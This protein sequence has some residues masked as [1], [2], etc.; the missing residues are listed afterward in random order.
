[1]FGEFDTKLSDNSNWKT[2][3]VRVYN[4]LYAAKTENHYKRKNYD[5]V[6]KEKLQFEIEELT[7]NDKKDNISTY[8]VL[9]VKSKEDVI[10]IR[11]NNRLTLEYI[12]YHVNF[13]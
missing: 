8:F 9:T 5:K 13:S 10:W 7:I 1:M 3:H 12:A 4:G 11:S 2:M 6:L